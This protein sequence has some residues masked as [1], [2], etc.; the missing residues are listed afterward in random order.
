MELITFDHLALKSAEI[1]RIVTNDGYNINKIYP[2]KIVRLNLL[3]L[4]FSNKF[5]LP[6]GT[7]ISI[8]LTD[9]QHE[10]E[11]HSIVSRNERTETGNY[12]VICNNL[13]LTWKS[14]NASSKYQACVLY[15]A[16]ERLKYLH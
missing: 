13:D 7:K 8:T 3:H 10:F 11:L 4:N 1:I 5:Y 16:N 14:P 6:I 2:I 12:T 15:T 9:C